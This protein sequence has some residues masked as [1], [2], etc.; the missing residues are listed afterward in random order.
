MKLTT[1]IVDDFLLCEFCD[2]TFALVIPS[3]R[4]ETLV[5]SHPLLPYS[6]LLVAR[7]EVSAYRSVCADD[8]RIVGHNANGIAEIQSLMIQEA[9]KRNVQFMVRIDDDA[10]CLEYMMTRNKTT[11]NDPLQWIAVYLS[12]ATMAIDAEIPVFGYNRSPKPQARNAQ[13]PFLLRD[14]IVGTTIGVTQSIDIVP[15]LKTCE[16]IAISLASIEKSGMILVDQRW[17]VVT[18][19]LGMGFDAGGVT[20]DRTIG[21]HEHDLNLLAS[22]YPDN[23]ILLTNEVDR[24]GMMRMRIN[25]ER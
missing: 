1:K 8:T 11:I 14:W 7:D 25:L 21:Q 4:R 9:F 17:Y 20:L 2:V 22:C 13:H 18:K 15:G 6:T 10:I 3:R 19:T 23:V 16:D 24:A 5:R 12:T